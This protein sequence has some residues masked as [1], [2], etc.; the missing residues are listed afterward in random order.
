[1][2]RRRANQSEVSA[3]SGAKVAELPKAPSSKRVDQSRT[4]QIAVD[5][6][7]AR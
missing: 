3:I 1:M 2:P 5:Q 4:V 7:A 6:A